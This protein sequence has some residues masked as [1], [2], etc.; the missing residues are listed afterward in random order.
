MQGYFNER[1][2]H[3]MVFGHFDETSSKVG[4]IMYAMAVHVVQTRLLNIGGVVEVQKIAAVNSWLQ[5]SLSCCVAKARA[6]LFLERLKLV[7]TTN[8]PARHRGTSAALG[9]S[10]GRQADWIAAHDSHPLTRW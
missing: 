1:S 3:V 2:Y 10:I 8:A 6:R 5:R 9:M 7:T 4:K